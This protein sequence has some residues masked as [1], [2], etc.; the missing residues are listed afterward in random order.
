MPETNIDTN[1]LSI[2]VVGFML[3]PNLI[4]IRFDNSF[5]IKIWNSSGHYQA[6]TDSE[7]G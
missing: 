5:D 2:F 4:H 1:A 6:A 3:I 7:Q